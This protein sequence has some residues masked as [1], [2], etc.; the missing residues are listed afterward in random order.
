MFDFKTL[1]YYGVAGILSLC[2]S[3]VLAAFA[4][5]QPGTRSARSSA[6]AILALGIGYIIAAYAP[7][8]PVWAMRLGTN[9]ILLSAGPILYSGFSAF[10]RNGEPVVDR[11]GWAAVAA[12]AIPFWYWGF[13]EPDG[14]Y[15]SAVFSLAAAVV[16]G[17]TSV[18]L[19]KTARRRAGDIP[20]GVMGALF[21]ILTAW[22]VIRGVLA[23]MAEP[24]SPGPRGA[25]PTTWATVFTYIVL[26]TLITAA[27]LWM[28]VGRLRIAGS[29]T[30]QTQ[31]AHGSV[32]TA[33]SKLLLLWGVVISLNIGI[34]SAFGVALTTYYDAEKSRLLRTAEVANDA[35][36]GHALH[37]VRQVDTVLFA[38]RGFYQRTRSLEETERF[39]GTL[40]FDREII[41]N[42]YLIG[43]NGT[44]VIDHD[45]ATGRAN[46]SD[47]AYF[48]FHKTHATDTPFV[49]QVESGR[50]TGKLHFRM[51]RRLDNPDGAFGG[52]V[53]AT[54][55]PDSFARYFRDL[56]GK[57]DAVASLL[58]T[59]DHQLRA[60]IPEPTSEW[61]QTPIE[62]PLWQALAQ[63]PS[64]SYE[65]T[66]SIDGIGRIFLYR[67]LPELPLVMV[68]GMSDTELM[69][70]VMERIR[71][72]A[73]GSVVVIMV[74]LILAV[75]LT[76]E[77]RRRDE[78]DRFLSMLNHELKTPLSVIRMVLGG[79]SIPGRI[80]DRVQRAVAD[81]NAIVERSLQADRLRHGQVLRRMALCQISELLQAI[82][83][84]SAAPQR[85]V[86]NA[87]D[88]PS[89]KTD[90]HLLSLIVANLIDNALKYGAADGEVRV[91]ARGALSKGRQGI[92]I[93]V[94]NPS[95]TAGM[96][97]PNQVFH[98]YYRAP[99]AH[100]KTG[101]GLG[102]YISAGFAEKLGG[103]LR[104]Q[105]TGD[106]VKFELWIPQ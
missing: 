34:I 82:T 102:L 60:R 19:L 26:I 41:G 81:M 20:V 44:V 104:Y 77:I 94:A 23:V 17:R 37:V 71:W 93:D 84:A 63:S 83:A 95:G 21:A 22:M 91:T 24:Q 100:G 38:V 14:N 87:G 29:A 15:R 36:V 69:N 50:V 3:L 13:V 76:I 35:F 56:L 5:F 90:P 46:V 62:S 79:E 9:M 39:I 96:P 33:R 101:S 106:E 52:I 73:V 98:K 25:N 7:S 10:C 66:S 65:N 97:D 2:L 61:W 28:E 89:I 64:G 99:G 8:L 70:G 86:V 48:L 67:K 18:V 40:G 16:N 72:P 78:Q 42:I 12:T 43:A 88:L 74:V 55:S 30:P 57:S 92:Q 45:G 105:P 6:A 4:R 53:L 27:T 80:K 75:L 1:T 32:S 85:V 11:F 59:E 58:G 51:S 31:L 47:R 68:T 54:V 49:S 103:R